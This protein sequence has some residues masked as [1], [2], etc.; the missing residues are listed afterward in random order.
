MEKQQMQDVNRP[1]TNSI[2]ERILVF[3]SL[4]YQFRVRICPKFFRIPPPIIFEDYGK[5]IKKGTSISKFFILFHTFT[6]KIIYFPQLSEKKNLKTFSKGGGGFFK[7]HHKHRETTA[8]CIWQI[9]YFH[10]LMILYFIYF[11]QIICF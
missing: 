5:K 6:N 2:Q 11:K 4:L 8:S 3:S 10:G 1:K 7:K 9:L